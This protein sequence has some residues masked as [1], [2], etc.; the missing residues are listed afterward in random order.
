MFRQILDAGR[1]LLC[2]PGNHSR[3]LEFTTHHSMKDASVVVTSLLQ[4]SPLFI[5]LISQNLCC[6]VL[7][8]SDCGCNLAQMSG[9][10]TK[11]VASLC[12]C[13]V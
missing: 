8:F 9:L 1:F 2:P 12:V 5:L 4:F 11:K 13:R 3:N 7:F 6:F 10:Q